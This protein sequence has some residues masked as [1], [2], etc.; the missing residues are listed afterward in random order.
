MLNIP[1]PQTLR[2]SSF[3]IPHSSFLAQRGLWLGPVA[4]LV[5]LGALVLL[6]DEPGRTL[7]LGVLVLAG[8]LAVLAWGRWRWV[9]GLAPVD[10]GPLVVWD[11]RRLTRFGGLA[12]AG[13]LVWAADTQFLAQPYDPF[14]TA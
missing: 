5:A 4:W 13:G 9:R 11:R 3:L 7:A 12:V 2:S 1:K 14:G 8:V 6:Q 10:A